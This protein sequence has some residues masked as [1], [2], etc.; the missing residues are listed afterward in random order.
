MSGKPAA[1]VR[2]SHR[3]STT[4]RRCGP[5]YRQ[6]ADE[7]DRCRLDRKSVH[8]PCGVAV[9]LPEGSA[10]PDAPEREV[11]LGVRADEIS[12]EPSAV[13]TETLPAQIVLSEYLGT[14]KVVA[15][16]PSRRA[17]QAEQSTV[18]VHDFPQAR[19][20]GQLHLTPT[21]GRGSRRL[22]V[23]VELGH[24]GGRTGCR[25]DAEAVAV[26][27]AVRQEA[28]LALVGVAGYEGTLTELS[29]ATAVSPHS[30]VDVVTDHR[31]VGGNHRS[32]KL[33]SW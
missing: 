12:V 5:D 19:V 14:E 21:R 7:P 23:V 30:P 9:Q 25:T 17:H 16:K 27:R 22:R 32:A 15:F 28:A 20:P 26:A 1:L 2:G 24:D 3:R 6:P 11:V 18:A 29:R 13:A 8:F 33:R 31:G 10:S 4:S